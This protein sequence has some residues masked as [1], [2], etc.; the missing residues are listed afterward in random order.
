MEYGML[1][2]QEQLKWCI[3]VY[4]ELFQWIDFCYFNMLWIKNESLI[5]D[6]KLN[7]LSMKVL[8]DSNAHPTQS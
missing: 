8:D 6:L 5:E 3:L 2:V 4:V 1:H 7:G